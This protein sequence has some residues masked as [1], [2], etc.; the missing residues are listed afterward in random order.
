MAKARYDYIDERKL[1]ALIIQKYRAG[2]TVKSISR[3][4]KHYTI[5]H[6]EAALPIGYVENVIYEHVMEWGW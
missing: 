5:E 1:K 6:K 3:E 2:Q 4:L